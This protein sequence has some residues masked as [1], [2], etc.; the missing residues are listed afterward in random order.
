MEPMYCYR[1]TTERVIDGDTYRLSVDL[2]FRCSVSI[3]G[4]LQGIDCPELDTENG[5]KAKAYVVGL[6][7]PVASPATS[8]VIMSY[9]DERSFARWIVS[10]WLPNGE[11]LAQH[12][13]ESKLA[14][15]MSR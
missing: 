1:A 13:I 3:E 10:I 9:K 6:L 7:T 15:V 14:K 11:S 8:L 4:R 5:K 2:G 12:L